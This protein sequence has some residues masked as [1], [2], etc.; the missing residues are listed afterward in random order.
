MAKAAVLPVPV[1]ACPVTSLP[2][3]I[4]GIIPRW[5]GVG[6]VYPKVLTACAN[7][8]RRFKLS[9]FSFTLN[10]SVIKTPVF[11]CAAENA[12]VTKA[13]ITAD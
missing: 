6:W 7:S 10:A 3:I 8:G 9:K 1:W 12:L 2:A 5:M 4:K 11:A 13:R